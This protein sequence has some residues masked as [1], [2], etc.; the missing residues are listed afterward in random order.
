MRNQQSKIL[1]I[2]VIVLSIASITCSHYVPTLTD[3][4]RNAFS[5]FVVPLQDRINSIGMNLISI[6]SD[7]LSIEEAKKRITELEDKVNTLTEENNNLK[8]KGYE[9]DRLRELYSL[10]DEY[11]QYNKIACRV[12]AKES[13]DWFQVFKI[14]KGSRDGIKVDMNVLSNKGLCGIVSSV[15]YNYATVRTIVDDK[16]R[17]SAMT[18]HSLEG[19]MVEG[20]I[21]LY[22]DNRMRLTGIKVGSTVVDGDRIVT[23]NISSK[24]LPNILIGYAADITIN[25]N[26]LSKSGYCIPVTDFN[27]LTE[28]MV[29]TRLKTDL[30]R[31]KNEN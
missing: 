7:R 23:S 8:S 26:Q 10:S 25:D 16:S 6:F 22:D 2:I 9:N 21:A 12:I 18:Q 29:I 3:P 27:N 19:C 13:E 28:V 20:D 5:F 30:M 14:D 1:I 4:V 17:V 11:P 24:F 15:G 31:D